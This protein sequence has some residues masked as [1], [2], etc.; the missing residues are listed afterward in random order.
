MATL[1]IT[2][3]GTREREYVRSAE[4]ADEIREWIGDGREG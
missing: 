1:T 4:L 2:H 3:S